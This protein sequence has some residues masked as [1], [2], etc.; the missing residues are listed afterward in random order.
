MAIKPEEKIEILQYKLYFEELEIV[1]SL[2]QKGQADLLAHVTN[3]R[4]HLSEE[5]DGQRE[6]FNEQFFGDRDIEKKMSDDD[7][8][9]NF[10]SQQVTVNTSDKNLKPEAWA[11][12]LYRKIVFST[13]PDKTQN[14]NVPLLVKKFNKYYSL[15][16][17]SF[18]EGSYEN[19]L[20]VG[21]ELDIE[22]PKNKVDEL[23]KPKNKKMNEEL[24]SKK[25]SIAYQWQTVPEE[26]KHVVLKNY[27]TSLGYI[28]KDKDIKETFERVKR[29]KRK[30]GTRPVNHLRKRV[31]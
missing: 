6:N 12:Q 16:V 18:T 8:V 13:H 4:E 17:D 24:S 31:K 27:L 20:F 11:K 9:T 26:N 15:A 5:V 30:V 2:F 22:L 3:F 7:P 1:E 29:I 23:I 21:F 25:N 28:F 10:D 19:L 14:F